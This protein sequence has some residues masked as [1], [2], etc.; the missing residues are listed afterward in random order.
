MEVL[1]ELAREAALEDDDDVS[2]I[3]SFLLLICDIVTYLHRSAT[4]M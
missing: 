4:K 2:S 1:A 3:A